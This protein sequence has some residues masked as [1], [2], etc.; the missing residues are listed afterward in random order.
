MFYFCFNIPI[1]ANVHNSKQQL[2]DIDNG[3]YI[4]S[5]TCPDEAIQYAQSN[6]YSFIVDIS[7]QEGSNNIIQP[8]LICLGSPFSINKENDNDIDVYYFPIIYE[9]KILYTLRVYKNDDTNY[10]GILSK[11]LANELQ[12]LT[13]ETSINNPVELSLN[14]GNIIKE[15]NNINEVLISSPIENN[16]VNYSNIYKK[17]SQVSNKSII[18]ARNLLNFEK[19]FSEQNLKSNSSKYLYLD[20]AETQGNNNWCCAYVGSSIIRYKTSYKVYAEDL[21]KY[22][23][24]NVTIS[25]LKEKAL[26]KDKLISYAKI[27]GLSPKMYSSNAGLLDVI[28]EIDNNC[29]I[30][31]SCNGNGDY[32]GKNHALAL[33]GYNTNTQKYSI[34]N[35]WNN[36]YETM[37]VDTRMYTINSSSSFFWSETIYNWKV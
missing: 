10:T 34:W 3:L 36:F 37:P 17:S 25:N 35:P 13:Y 32:L 27:K 20:L 18:N 8:D 22:Y 24:P 6:L 4:I 33:R 31:L 5:Q 28:S 21:M 26:S 14:N 2:K 9:N 15:I 11:Y 23:Y 29:P 12:T 19:N 16:M 7:D 1:K 30:Y